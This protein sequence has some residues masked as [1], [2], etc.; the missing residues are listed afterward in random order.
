MEGRLLQHSGVAEAGVTGDALLEGAAAGTSLSL[1]YCRYLLTA[2]LEAVTMAADVSFDQPQHNTYTVFSDTWHAASLARLS[3][4]DIANAWRLSDYLMLDAACVGCL[5]DMI[6]QRQ[7]RSGV[8]NQLV[9]VPS[10]GVS[11]RLSNIPRELSYLPASERRVHRGIAVPGDVEMIFA[12]LWG[13]WDTLL[14]AH[15]AGVAWGVDATAGAAFGGHLRLIQRL[16]QAGCPW[17]G[18][19]VEYA[20]RNGHSKLAIWALEHGAPTYESW[21]SCAAGYGCV[22]VLQWAWRHRW[23]H[24]VNIPRVRQQ[25]SEEG[26]SHVVAWLDEVVASGAAHDQAAAV[27]GAV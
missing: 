9:A 10:H 24:A 21:L 25:A 6:L 2:L 27:A 17:C 13:H 15:A 1:P 20:C 14:Q 16:R 8:A 4:A 3:D 22:P 12:A 18:A 26:Q 23:L 11:K 19:I 7:A 5:E